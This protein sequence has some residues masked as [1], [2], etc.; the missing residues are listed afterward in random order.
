MLRESALEHLVVVKLI[1]GVHED[2]ILSRGTR[3]SFVHRVVNSFVA[4]R[5]NMHASVL[6]ALNHCERAIGRCSVNDPMLEILHRLM[7]SAQQRSLDERLR[8]VNDRNYGAQR[9]L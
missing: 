2:H 6:V 8:I 3:K 1:A 9:G 7:S 4:L 5:N